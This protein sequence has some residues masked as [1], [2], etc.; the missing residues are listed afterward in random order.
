MRSYPTIDI[1]LASCLFALDVPF[2][3]NTPITCV[4]QQRKGR[5]FNQFT[6]WFDIEDETKRKLCDVLV[7]AYQKAKPSFDKGKA[8]DLGLAWQHLP[9]GEYVLDTEHPL[10][11]QMGALWRREIYVDQMRHAEPMKQ[12]QQGNKDVL[13]STRAS[14]HTKDLMKKHL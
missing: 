12:F 13:I 3:S 4:V 8:R 11:F 9:D 6:F 2:R 10:Y 1:K 14:Q 7:S 5:D